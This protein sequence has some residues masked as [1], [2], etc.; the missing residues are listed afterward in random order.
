VHFLKDGEISKTVRLEGED[1]NESRIFDC[2]KE[3]DI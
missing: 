3:L 2:L 1:V